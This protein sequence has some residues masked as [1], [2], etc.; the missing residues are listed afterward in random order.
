[1]RRPVPVV[2][3]TDTE[4][5]GEVLALGMKEEIGARTGDVD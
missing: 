2:G 4:G 3:S 1:M 5:S